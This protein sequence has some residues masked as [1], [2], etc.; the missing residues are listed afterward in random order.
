MNAHPHVCSDRSRY[1]TILKL[2]L[3]GKITTFAMLRPTVAHSQ[4][5]PPAEVAQAPA[6]ATGEPMPSS[7]E[8]A[9]K[10]ANPLASLVSVPFQFNRIHGIGPQDEMQHVDNLEPIV[11][12][13]VSRNW[14]LITRL[15]V[16][17]VAQPKGLGSARG[18]S[19]IV[20]SFF[21][22]PEAGAGRWMWGAGP[23]VTLPTTSDPMLGSG[24]WSAGPTFGV[25]RQRA[26][27][28]YVLLMNQVWSFASAG[29]AD[30]TAVSQGFIEPV[31]SHAWGSG[32]SVTMLSETSV[33]WRASR[34]R[35][36][37]TVPVTVTVGKIKH[38][39]ALPINMGVGGGIFLVK[40]EGGPEWL[41]RSGFTFILPSPG[42]GKRS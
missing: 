32:A 39:G 13:P 42:S 33:N 21:L 15:I 25:L 18:T 22:V 7:Q 2:A 38:L 5:S 1:R 28:T 24:K 29:H 19:D 16:P 27:M 30:R 12:F 6:A 23:V 41:I 20:A 14:N 40:P 10:L 17:Y 34:A 3:I 8:L 35:D 36:K 37:W 9:M 11:P 26:G 31:I 4:A